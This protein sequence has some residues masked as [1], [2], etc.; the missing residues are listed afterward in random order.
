MAEIN[1]VGAGL[2]GLVAAINCARS[3]H[4]VTVLERRKRVGGDPAVHPGVD[5]TIM[6]P[7]V[8][9]KFIGV[10]LKTPQ[11]TR[12]EEIEFYMYGKKFEL[13]PANYSGYFYPIMP[14]RFR[15]SRLGYSGTGWIG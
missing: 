14:N 4:D 6:Q 9:G 3:G 7:E 13:D 1:V 10:E 5:G 15:Q 8:L 11:V 2:S 12:M